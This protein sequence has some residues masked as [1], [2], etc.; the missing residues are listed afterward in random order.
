[1]SKKSYNAE[2]LDD[3]K[4]ASSDEKNA[5]EAIMR[6]PSGRR[7]LYNL[8]HTTCH[9]D[10]LSHVP[11]DPMTTAFNEGGRAIG[12]NVRDEARASPNYLKMLE[13]NT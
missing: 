9:A 13:E 6:T 12:L 2:D 5:L 7:W 8:I 3:I 11:G 10:R 4:E 1:M